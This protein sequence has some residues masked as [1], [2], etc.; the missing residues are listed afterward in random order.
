MPGFTG[1]AAFMVYPPIQD[2][3]TVA[4]RML[5]DQRREHLPS[6][7]VPKNRHYKPPGHANNPYTD[8]DPDQDEASFETSFD[9]DDISA[10]L[11]DDD[12]VILSPAVSPPGQPIKPRHELQRNGSRTNPVSVTEP[13]TVS[14]PNTE[15]I[16]VS[17][18]KKQ[19]WQ[20]RRVKV[21]QAQADVVSQDP[22]VRARR[23]AAVAQLSKFYKHG[24][25]STSNDS[26]S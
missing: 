2:D 8:L 23:A 6:L 24:Q 14:E 10:D 17:E 9:G 3:A 11:F 26:E 18:K 5:H 16:T 13:N 4:D 15:P 22:V 12:R 20:T 1:T 7:R 25:H 21:D 19:T